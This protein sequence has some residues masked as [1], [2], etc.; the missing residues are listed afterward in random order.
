MSASEGSCG[1]ASARKC[2][3]PILRRDRICGSDRVRRSL[4][5]AALHGHELWPPS[6]S[7]TGNEKLCTA[8]SDEDRER[9]CQGLGAERWDGDKRH[10]PCGDEAG[11]LLL[12]A[13]VSAQSAGR[14]QEPPSLRRRG[15]NAA[16]VARVSVQSAGTVTGATL[17]AETRQRRCSDCQ[18][19]GA[20]R[21]HSNF[22][23]KESGPRDTELAMALELGRLSGKGIRQG[24]ACERECRTRLASR[25]RSRK[26]FARHASRRTWTRVHISLRTHCG[27][28]EVRRPLP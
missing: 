10:P 14:C 28:D 22:Q 19:F 16:S 15:R 27:S 13:R 24:R 11:T 9:I 4:S 7:W 26:A 6:F 20:E 23:G 18:S 17:L 12:I 25:M 21:I 2:R 8:D 1:Q 3:G 5:L